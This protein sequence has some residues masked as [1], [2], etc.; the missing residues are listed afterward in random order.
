MTESISLVDFFS[1]SEVAL[2]DYKPLYIGT[3]ES[4][5]VDSALT[6]SFVDD[7]KPHVFLPK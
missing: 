1:P 3:I 7:S 4:S 6:T 5:F 2:I